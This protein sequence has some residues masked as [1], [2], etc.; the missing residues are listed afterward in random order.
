MS[1]PGVR[2]I[3]EPGESEYSHGKGLRASAAQRGQYSDPIDPKGPWELS[4]YD[5]GKA[6]QRTNPADPAAVADPTFEAAPGTP[7]NY[8]GI[9]WVR[10]P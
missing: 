4:V 3:V 10:E 1:A 9:E 6:V 8:N 5:Q 2:R 7:A